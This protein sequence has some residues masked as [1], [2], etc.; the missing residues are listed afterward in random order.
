MKH[1]KIKYR[2]FLI[3]MAAGGL[4]ITSCNKQDNA[5]APYQGSQLMSNITIQDSS[6]TPKLTWIG[7]YVSV[8]GVNLGMYA[9][10]DTSLVWLIYMDNDQIHYPVEFGTLP[11]GAQN[12]TEEYGGTSAESLIEDS[13]YTFWVMKANDWNKISSMQN[14]IIYLDSS[15]TTSFQIEADTVRFSPTGHTQNTQKLDNYVN[16]YDYHMRGR[17]ADLFVEQPRTSNNPRIVWQ[18]KQEG[19]T[20]TLIAAIGI[21]EGPQYSFSSIVWEVYSVSDSAGATYYGKKNVIPSPL[22]S[23]QEFPETFVFT[24]YPAEGLQRNTTYYVWIASKEWDGENRRLS[25][26]YYAYA[27][28]KTN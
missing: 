20:D 24:E 4:F 9:A 11:S 8:V 17:L 3:L 5:L 26:D 25:T 1:L 7:G 10:L 21:V 13:T 15:I 22:I 19:V 27:Y 6:T 14:I 23:G 16:F 28:F 18:I 12:L 2:S